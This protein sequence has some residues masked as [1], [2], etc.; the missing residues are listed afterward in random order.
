MAELPRA[1]TPFSL[2]GE[3]ER[4]GFLAL[5]SIAGDG[6]A[7]FYPSCMSLVGLLPLWVL[8]ER[9]TCLLLSAH[10]SSYHVLPGMGL[11][12]SSMSRLAVT[13]VSLLLGVGVWLGHTDV[14][15]V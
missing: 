13:I 3:T 5:W 9:Q 6:T 2:A 1:A 4:V 7:H 12:G 11:G 10:K 14:C 15:L 8:A